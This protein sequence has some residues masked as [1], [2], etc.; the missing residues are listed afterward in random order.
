MSWEDSDR[1]PRRLFHSYHI[2]NSSD[3]Y[4]YTLILHLFGY[5]TISIGGHNQE[6]R[7]SHSRGQYLPVAEVHPIFPV[8][9]SHNRNTKSPNSRLKVNEVCPEVDEGCIS[10]RYG[11]VSVQVLSGEHIVLQSQ[12]KAA[13]ASQLF[14]V[15]LVSS[16]LL[17]TKPVIILPLSRLTLEKIAATNQNSVSLDSPSFSCRGSDHGCTHLLPLGSPWVPYF[18][19]PASVCPA[20]QL[21]GK[22]PRNPDMSLENRVSVQV[23]LR[24]DIAFNTLRV[25]SAV[26]GDED[27]RCDAHGQQA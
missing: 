22:S 14:D 23:F 15:Y 24:F 11:P 9:F 3:F 16:F 13:L 21:H 4:V 12:S 1:H 5:D 17:L 7:S 8:S 18:T 2:I 10:E 27:L 20:A 26:S 19:T 6:Y 25:S